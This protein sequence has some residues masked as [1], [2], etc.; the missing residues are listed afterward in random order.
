ML[1]R[2]LL[3]SI[4]AFSAHGAGHKITFDSSGVC[5]VDGQKMFPLS[6]AVLPDPGAK[7]PG[8]QS[9]WQ[10]LADGGVNLVRVTPKTQTEN[11]GWTPK[12]YQLAHEYFDALRSSH[13]LVWLWTGEELGHFTAEETV[14]QEKLKKLVE[15]F[16]DEPALLGWKGE[17]EPLW[18]NLERPGSRAP[19]SLAEPYKIVHELD[20]NHPMLVIQAP[21]GT[22]AQNAEYNPYLD[23]TG[24]DVF[25]VGYPPGGHTPKSPNK[26]ISMVGDWTKTMV[27]AAHGKPVWMTLQ[28]SWSGVIKPGKTLRFPTFEQERFM[29]YQAII[30]GARGLNYFG[31]GN[32]KTLND[33]DRKLGFNW[34]F[35]DRILKPLLAEVNDKSPLHAGLLAPNSKLP[36][37]VQP[38]D[39]MEFVVREVGDEVYLLACKR[40]GPTVQVRF[41]GLPGAIGGG[42]VL[43]EE[44]RKVEVKDGAFT[45]WFA[46]FDVHVYRFKR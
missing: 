46:P 38:G 10:E 18:G 40:Q 34:T 44:P 11:Y 1:K 27:E 43:Y 45:D 33:R 7:A 36:V 20:P 17:D 6:I 32:L 19:E 15:T 23:V 26:E 42:D 13:L 12:G 29:T 14:K 41:T 35:W 21:R 28:I 25:P 9:V 39:G 5:E 30:D 24:M 22:A 4:F 8:G 16:R 2:I 31:G 3:A 37:Q